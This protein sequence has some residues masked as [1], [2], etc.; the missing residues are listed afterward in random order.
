MSWRCL[1]TFIA[2]HVWL[3]HI[4]PSNIVGLDIMHVIIQYDTM[5]YDPLL[6]NLM[7][8]W[9]L[10]II[11]WNKYFRQNSNAHFIMSPNCELQ[12]TWVHHTISVSPRYFWLSPSNSLIGWI[13]P[14]P[15]RC[16]FQMHDLPLIQEYEQQCIN[17]TI[18]TQTLSYIQW[19]IEAW[20]ICSARTPF[21]SLSMAFH[22]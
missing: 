18:F 12:R 10:H 3:S 17:F 15:F 8:K 7:L 11:M 19:I 9:T 16:D 4:I 20:A 2:M 1:I 13:P 6:N 22:N 5:Q 21:Q 14:S